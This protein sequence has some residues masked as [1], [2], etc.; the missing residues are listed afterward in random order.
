MESPVLQAQKRTDEKASDLRK[1]G[2]IPAVVYG[3]G[4][5]ANESMVI[6]VEYQ[7]FR[8]A[9]RISGESTVIDL[10]LEGK[11]IPVLVH[12]FDQNPIT[13]SFDHI[14]FF[15][16]K[17]SQE[18]HTHIPVTFIGTAPVIKEKNAILV[19]SKTE[20]NVR[21]LPKNLVHDIS[22]D[23]STLQN[24]HE[25]ISVKDL[26]LPEGIIVTDNLDDILVS[27]A[28]PKVD[29]TAEEEAAAAAAAALTAEGEAGAVPGTGE[30]VPAA[31]PEKGK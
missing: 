29:K 14:D 13:S 21:C 28:P 7:S 3:P 20:V 31:A 22:V 26:I 17:L 5:S 16:V 10:E 15:A 6:T 23:I 4:L 24:Y 2:L 25:H 11:K 9:I 19:Y 8:K 27:A 30:G 18:V 1:K 12:S